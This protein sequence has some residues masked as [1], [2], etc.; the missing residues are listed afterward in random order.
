MSYPSGVTVENGKELTPTQ[1]KDQ[2]TVS[3]TADSSKYYTLVF[4]DPDAPSRADPKLR[5]IRHWLV[6]NI[7]GNNISEGDTIIEYRGS[8]P[9]Q[10]TGLHRYIFLIFEQENKIDVSDVPRTPTT[11]R[12]H[13]VS[14]STRELIRKYNLGN[15]IAGNFYQAQYDDYVPILQSQTTKQ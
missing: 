10:G 4:T 14:T 13:R 15:P 2:P 9:P 1:V 8:G 7:P 12:E 5:E 11:S 6:Q 3:W